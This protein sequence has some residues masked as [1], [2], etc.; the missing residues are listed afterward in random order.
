[1]A[2]SR[3]GARPGGRVGA[4]PIHDQG[5]HSPGGA[6]P[7]KKLVALTFDLCET[8]GEAAGYD[9]A[10]VDYLRSQRIKATYFAGGQWM[11]SH[12]ARAQQL[13][14]DPLFEIGTHGWV[15]RNARLLTGAE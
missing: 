14:S 8:A 1:M 7:G 6:A 10:I 5:C 12:K 13:L 4:R 9:G 11:A 2:A 15:H 3:A